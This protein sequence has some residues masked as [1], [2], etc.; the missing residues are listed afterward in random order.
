MT[1]RAPL[2]APYETLLIFN[3]T[4]VIVAVYVSSSRVSLR[5][6]MPSGPLTDRPYREFPSLS[7][8]AYHRRDSP[9][10]LPSFRKS[11]LT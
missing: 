10:P 6:G 7:S 3:L 4:S 2:P 5:S 1:Q 9:P 8:R 11:R